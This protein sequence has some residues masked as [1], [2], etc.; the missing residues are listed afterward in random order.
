MCFLKTVY[1]EVTVPAC[2]PPVTVPG[3]LPSLREAISRV[4]KAAQQVFSTAV[5]VFPAERPGHEEKKRSSRLSV[6]VHLV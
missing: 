2:F 4:F 1:G 5:C 6:Y 3:T